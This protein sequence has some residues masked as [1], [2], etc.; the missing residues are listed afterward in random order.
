V[1][2]C[3]PRLE[4][5]LLSNL[6][7]HLFPLSTPPLH[8][9]P[10]HRQLS[11]LMEVKLNMHLQN[12]RSQLNPSGRGIRRTL[13][14][15]YTDFR[16]FKNLNSH[17]HRLSEWIEFRAAFLDETLRHDGLGNFFGQSNCSNCE[18]VAGII[19]CRDCAD[20]ALLKCPECVVALHQN[21]P[22]HRVEVRTRFSHL[23]I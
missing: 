20:G 8:Q 2:P 4:S 16:A 17:Q 10:P 11:P 9:H 7:V 18:N 14:V 6:K 1:A 23:I 21:F 13:Y 22:L 5:F 19:K 15:E 12:R 3:K